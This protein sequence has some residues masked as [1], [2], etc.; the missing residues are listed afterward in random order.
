M[1][2]N[3]LTLDVVLGLAALVGILLTAGAVGGNFDTRVL[4]IEDAQRQLAKL[5]EA[6]AALQAEVKAM[7]ANVERIDVRQERMIEVVSAMNHEN[8]KRRQ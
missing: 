8:E 5:P 7:S 3:R 4:N 2:P 6:M 1:T